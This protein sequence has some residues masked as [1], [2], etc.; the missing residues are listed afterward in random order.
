MLKGSLHGSEKKKELNEVHSDKEEIKDI[1]T[2][3]VLEK[4]VSDIIYEM[5]DKETLIVEQISNCL[6]AKTHLEKFRVFN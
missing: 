5:I 3:Y 4:G 2:D 1:L 6:D